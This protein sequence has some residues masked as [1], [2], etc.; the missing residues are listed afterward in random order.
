VADRCAAT[1]VRLIS[2]LA[3]AVQ[4]VDGSAPLDVTLPELLDALADG[5]RLERVGPE[6]PLV[7]IN[8]IVPATAV[9]VTA[10]DGQEP[11][12]TR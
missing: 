9:V 7:V 4:L 12:R 2:G 5:K 10:C 8:R 11:L 1:P 6:I 3:D